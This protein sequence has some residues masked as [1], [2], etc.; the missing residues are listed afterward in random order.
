MYNA[1]GTCNR[2]LSKL[3][4]LKQMTRKEERFF[5]CLNRPRRT[6]DSRKIINDGKIPIS[7]ITMFT[8][9]YHLLEGFFFGG[10]IFA[11]V[12]F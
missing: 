3:K 7:S 1:R 10:T 12:V 9:V 2:S 8:F 11:I 6:Y 4:V 5:L